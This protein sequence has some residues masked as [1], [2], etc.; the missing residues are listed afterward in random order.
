M[1]FWI[2]AGVGVFLLLVLTGAVALVAVMRSGRLDTA[3]ARP[4]AAVP[5]GGM[6]HKI[7]GKW[8]GTED[9]RSFE[10]CADGTANEVVGWSTFTGK[11]T[12]KESDRLTVRFDNVPHNYHFKFASD[13]DFTLIGPGGRVL[14]YRRVQALKP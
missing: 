4:G 2:L 12:I 5:P 3:P 8:Q 9:S 6:E 10:F 1:R 14:Q 11:Y 7:V 13:N